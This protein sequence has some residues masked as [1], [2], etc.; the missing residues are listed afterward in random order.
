MKFDKLKLYSSIIRDAKQNGLGMM[1]NKDWKL[2]RNSSHRNYTKQTS[3]SMSPE[4][5]VVLEPYTQRRLNANRWSH[6]RPC[7]V[8]RIIHFSEWLYIAHYQRSDQLHLFYVHHFLFTTGQLVSV[9][10]AIGS[11]YTWI[12][13]IIDYAYTFNLFPSNPPSDDIYDL[14]TQ[15]ISTRVFMV[16]FFLSFYILLIYASTTKDIKTITIS[17]PDLQQYHRLYSKYPQTLTCSCSQISV[18]FGSFITIDYSLHHI[19]NSFF[20]S[21][22]WI[23]FLTNFNGTFIQS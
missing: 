14:R 10:G 2:S 11:I 21:D 17:H 9:V 3:A 4:I 22:A 20:V 12:H 6:F 1:T 19:C 23:M 18:N 5:A 15:R 8:D 13:Q 7:I 16:V